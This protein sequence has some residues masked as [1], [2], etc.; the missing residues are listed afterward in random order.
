MRKDLKNEFSELLKKKWESSSFIKKKLLVS[1]LTMILV[2]V[3]YFIFWKYTWI[4]WILALFFFS[5][6]VNIV[7]IFW[8][9]FWFMNKV[10]K[11]GNNIDNI[12]YNQLISEDL[13]VSEI[14]NFSPNQ[15]EPN[16]SCLMALR[17]IILSQNE[18]IS[19][20]WQYQMPFF[21]YQD[22]RFCYLWVDKKTNQPYLGVVD[23]NQINHPDFIQEKRAKM[24]IMQFDPAED[25]PIETIEEVLQMAIKF[26]SKSDF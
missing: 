25:L 21:F 26:L 13:V 22:K 7:L 14:D 10:K 11:I 15:L 6:L 2:V 18:Y 17:E 24:K 1:S 9:K 3:L 12:A 4:Q 5:S 19:E 8:F 20:V 23:G 16:Q